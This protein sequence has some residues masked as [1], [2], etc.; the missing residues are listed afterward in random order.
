MD[1]RPVLPPE[2]LQAMLELSRFLEQ[3][4]QPAALLGPDGE[5]VPLP[6]EVYQVLM[7]VVRAMNDRKAIT[8]AP[9]NQRLTTQEAADVLGISRPTLVKLLDEHEIPYD[10]PTGGRHRRLR[11]SDV[12]EYR[13]RR[14][15]DRRI[16][17]DEMTRQAGEDGLYEDSA[18]DYREAL[19]RARGKAS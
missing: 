14:R 10:Q 3:H 17:L 15:I 7:N 1:D 2:D 18:A 19:K 4:D 13:D 16:R 8:I 6:F 9:L 11:L 5:Q 12:L